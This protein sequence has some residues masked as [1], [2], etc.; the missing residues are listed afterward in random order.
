MIIYDNILCIMVKRSCSA[1]G[2]FGLILF[3]FGV[4]FPVLDYD[5]E[6]TFLETFL[7]LN[8]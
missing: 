2:M 4:N 8:V 1:R 5:R 6:S 3:D 7:A